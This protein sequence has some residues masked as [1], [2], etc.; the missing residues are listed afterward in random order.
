MTWPIVRGIADSVGG[1]TIL[2]CDAHG[3]LYEEYRGSRT[4]HACPFAR[5]MEEGLV[6]RLVQ[7]GI[8]S[9]T[10]HLREQAK[11]Y[12][13]EVHEMKDLAAGPVLDLAGPLYVS[14]DLDVL[15]P[16]CAPGVSHP[17]GGGLTTREALTIIHGIT[18]P[19]VGADVVEMNPT[20][21]PL[22]ITAHAAS[23]IVKEIAGMML[24]TSPGR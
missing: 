10:G 3:D 20:R 9:M 24:T 4:S 15:D 22:G 12:G 18:A 23:K 7:V 14:F 5:I 16:G 17:E 1:L 19:I 13:V 8:R 6:R 2:H 11:R 21:D